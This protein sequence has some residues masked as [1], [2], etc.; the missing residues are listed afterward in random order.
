M[1]SKHSSYIGQ[2]L[3][4]RYEVLD[5]VGTGSMGQVF[6]VK[7]TKA[8][9]IKALKLVNIHKNRVPFE[10][11]MRFRAEGDILRKLQHPSIIK[12]FDFFNEGDL[13]GLVMEYLPYPN[14]SVF[15]KKSGP[16]SLEKSFFLI[17]TLTEALI[18]IHDKKLVHLDLK[19]SNIL[20]QSGD[21]KEM[22]IKILDFGFSQIIG[23]SDSRTG[24]TLSYM[25][26]EQTGILHKTIDH[27][28]DLYALGIIL[29]EVLVG[30]VP[31]RSDDPAMLVYQHIAQMPDPPSNTR[32]DIPGIFEKILLKLIRKDPDDRYRTTNG[33]LND[34]K[35]Y[36]RLFLEKPASEIQ[37]ELGED[38]HWD[39]FP[40]T[41]PFI[42]RIKEKQALYTIINNITKKPLKQNRKY[43]FHIDEDKRLVK[44]YHHVEG[45]GGLYLIEGS[46]GTGKTVLL[47]EI[48]NEL[49]SQPGVT[50]FHQALKEEYETPLKTIKTILQNLETYLKRLHHAQ[51]YTVRKFLQKQFKDNFGI[52]REFIPSFTFT[53]P[54]GS[55]KQD[56]RVRQRTS[57]DYLDVVYNLLVRITRIEKRLIIIV[58]SFQF[59]EQTS[60]DLILKLIER[61]K[62]LPIL[63]IL[64]YSYEDL[65]LA[66][67]ASINKHLGE[68][69]T[70]H[71]VL[72]PLKEAEVANLIQRLF[73]DKLY[74]MP[75]FLDTLYA[76]TQGNPSQIRN[77]LQKL[78][79]RRLIYFDR[80]AWHAKSDEII[81]FIKTQ[82]TVNANLA[83]LIDF[84]REEIMALSRGSIFLRSFSFDAL[85]AL[86]KIPP[87]L[88]IF[89]NNL[90]NILDRAV[91]VN[92]LSV[93]S[94]RFYSFCNN[95][96]RYALLSDLEPELKASLYK[97]VATYLEKSTLPHSPDAVFDIAR[98]F[99]HAGDA[100]KAMQYYIKAAQLTDNGMYSDRQAEIY[101][102]KALLQLKNLKDQ[103]S[104]DTATQFNVRYNAI[105]HTQAFSREYD[106]LWQEL[107]EIEPWLENDRIRRLQFIGLQISLSFARGKKKEMLKYGQNLMSMEILPHEEKYI[108]ESV[109]QLGMVV[110]DKTFSERLELLKDGVEIA[111]K[112]RLYYLTIGPAS[113]HGI[114]SAY[115]LRFKE[116]ETYIDHCINQLDKP[117]LEDFR[118][119]I[120]LW[121]MQALELERGNFQKALDFG[122]EISNY[123]DLAGPIAIVLYEA[124][125]AYI[126]GMLGNFADALQ[127]YE[128]L[129]PNI[130][131]AAQRVEAL[132]VYF[133]RIQVA[134]RMK[135]PETALNYFEIVKP[136]IKLRPDPYMEAMFNILAANAYLELRQAEDAEKHIQV[137]AIIA[138]DLKAPLLDFHLDF[139]RLHLNWIN[140]SNSDYI[141]QAHQLLD[142]MLGK[143]VTG[144]YEIY[145][146]KLDN[147]QLHPTRSSTSISPYNATD[148]SILK[149]FE[150]SQKIT[151]THNL[152]EL[153]DASLEGAMQLT[154]A[155]H[156]YLFT[157]T[158]IEKC[159]HGDAM[160][161][162]ITK[163]ALG[164]PISEIEHCFSSAIINSVLETKKIIITRDARSESQWSHSRSIRV[165]QLRSI[166]V[167]PII[168]DDIL[169]G[170][171]YLDNHHAKSVF[172]AKDR[173]IVGI[174]A[175]QV[176]IALNHAE[177][178]VKQQEIS[179]EN[180]RLY[181]EI[182]EYSRT[183]EQQVTHRT[184]ELEELNRNLENKVREE[185]DRRLEQEQLLIQQSK[186]AAMGEMIG[187]IAHQWRQPL[188][189]ISTVAGNMQIFLEL[190]RISKDE[191]SSLLTT[192]NEQVQYLSGTINDFREFFSPKKKAELIHLE[193]ILG[194]TLKLIGKSLEHKNIQLKN[195]CLFSKPIVTYSNELM[196]VFLNIIKNAQDALIENSVTDPWI[197]IEST[198]SDQHQTVT[199]TD[200][201]GGVP[202]EIIDKI[203]EPYF[204]T[205]EEKTGTGL[206]LYMSK[207]IVEKHCRGELTV[208][209][210]KGGA[211]FEIQLPIAN[212]ELLVKAEIISR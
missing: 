93:S 29:Y 202:E 85:K 74:D 141:R 69:Y 63:F 136:I 132:P 125:M 201:A 14:L 173:E 6:K 50:W 79:D 191:F 206:G 145:K 143:G 41:N 65:S 78:I 11:L 53:D 207:I 194:K 121:S 35:K 198:E 1:A 54:D 192:I 211:S 177:S 159:I 113:T 89:E 80:Q 13:Y 23:M 27:R 137:A 103:D 118:H 108:A 153:F 167:A 3:N 61:V 81:Q 109:I 16:F 124:S 185:L 122:I 84:T 142:D 31:F 130:D 68:S 175:T 135:E 161:P 24:G 166:L 66:H 164:Q 76:S 111:L 139:V 30:Q 148:N 180:S 131:K 22:Q 128:K 200:N 83:P 160:K 36:H 39:G 97:T 196:Q 88:P 21:S 156:G 25:A 112:H 72:S 102:R 188:S 92:V 117:G 52:I 59:V 186:M 182:R 138:R 46:R 32:K 210:I 162:R 152:D 91:Q 119:L 129:L 163:N 17:R 104:L 174:F 169:K 183:L 157:C 10:A 70:H 40:Q 5:L 134:L 115:L 19:P 181:E 168:F 87:E 197:T 37:F 178:Y 9:E 184:Q 204:S 171:I 64:S 199:F 33:F 189:S 154:G 55:K 165:N 71:L 151:T 158:D 209:N 114:L 99:D 95:D 49:Q 51:Q 38:D 193:D 34:L 126:H 96:T 7:D 144:F 123:R 75:R 107:M 4:H 101:Y 190:D 42:G 94:Q 43:R 120:K 62:E 147:W 44:R 100:L 12:Y 90:L 179:A 26:P 127:L 57:D 212:K 67:K 45:N 208:R 116:A 140:S 2:I 133:S 110:S 28:A 155:N 195:N 56:H 48:Y 187:M 170:F 60:V 176:A 47:T 20:I 172:S 77:T 146:E 86:V 105:R 149:L 15:L 73:S 8:N 150:I 18:F 106:E 98:H 203:F 58:D 82:R 205:K